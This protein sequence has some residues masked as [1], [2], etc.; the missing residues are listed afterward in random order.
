M[1]ARL[2]RA[3]LVWLTVQPWS[4]LCLAKPPAREPLSILRPNA[5]V[6]GER[7]PFAPA[8]VEVDGEREVSPIERFSLGEL[9]LVATVNGVGHPRALIEDPTGLGFITVVGNAVGAE[10]HKIIAIGR[11][12]VVLERPSAAGS[13]AARVVMTLEADE[14]ATGER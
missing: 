4:G 6:G 14:R 11:G 13:L 3:V 1:R 8:K 9:R 12:E 5:G 2:L 7:D 10:H